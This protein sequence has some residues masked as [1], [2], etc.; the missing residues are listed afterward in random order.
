M[1]TTDVAETKHTV[2]QNTQKLDWTVEQVDLIRRQIAKDATNDELKMFLYVASKSG[3]DPLSRQIYFQKV[4]GKPTFITAIDGYRLIA[5]R[6]GLHA[7]TDDAVFKHDANGE[8][9]EATVTVY[10]MVGGVRCPFTATARWSEY[11]P[12]KGRD[13]MWQKMPYTMLSKCAES[14]SLRK[15]FPNELSGVYTKEE[16]DQAGVDIPSI[17]AIADVKPIT[18]KSYVQ[19]NIPTT[20][21]I[22]QP[23]VKS[24]IQQDFNE[25]MKEDILNTDKTPVPQ[26][27]DKEQVDYSEIESMHIPAGNN[28]TI[29]L[30]TMSVV[31]LD[32]YYKKM[33]DAVKGRDED[34]LMGTTKLLL[35]ELPHYI[36]Y[37]KGLLNG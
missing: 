2:V 19:P 26:F 1:S 11:C 31:D 36:K 29:S 32:L 34:S 14:L 35:K 12:P 13:F 24:Q 17:S 18:A 22:E 8:L 21:A 30:K 9:K 5:A 6:T 37:R 3:L 4:G 10:R 23:P 15:S 33:L 25:L 7:G 20:T 27:L 28:K 16:M